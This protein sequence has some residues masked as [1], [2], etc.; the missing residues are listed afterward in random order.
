MTRAPLTLRHLL[1]TPSGGFRAPWRLA[2]FLV[3]SV[4][5]L[6]FA[7]ALVYPLFRLATRIGGTP[8]AAGATLLCVGLLL[9]HAAAL[10]WLDGLPWRDADMGREAWRPRALAEGTLVGTVAVALPILVL[11]AVGWLRLDTAPEGSSLALAA[12]LALYLAP[13][14]LWEE[15]LFRGYAFGVLRDALGTVAAVG[16]TSLA[17]GLVHLQ[18]AGASALPIAV[19]VIAGVWLAAVRLSTRSVWAAWLAHLAWNWTLAAIWHAPVSGL[20]MEV[21]DY[22]LVDAGPDWATGGSWGPE[23]GIAA[24]LALT[25]GTGFL[26]A[27]PGGPRTTRVDRA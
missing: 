14:A 19:V 22:R 16:L 21:V 23:G 3:A 20:G 12:R 24:A 5:G 2:T 18:N 26:L 15:L 7:Q 17:F 4:A 9:G 1:R 27:R 8:I 13:A 25:A 10:R 11:V 6:A